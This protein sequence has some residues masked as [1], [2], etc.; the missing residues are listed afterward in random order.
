MSPKPRPIVFKPRLGVHE[1]VALVS[2]RTQVPTQDILGDCREP[3]IADARHIA[4]YLC[5]RLLRM[6]YPE[7]ARAFNRRCHSSVMHSVSR[8]EAQSGSAEFATFIADVVATCEAEIE[9]RTLERAGDLTA[10]F[11]SPRPDP[12]KL[13]SA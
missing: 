2:S 8:V 11:R 5:R 1:I 13:E 12:R 7:L 4:V 9:R 10:A 3:A 6:S